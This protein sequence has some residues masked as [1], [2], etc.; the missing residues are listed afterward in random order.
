MANAQEHNTISIRS[1]LW[2]YGLVASI[3]SLAAAT[4]DRVAHPVVSGPTARE[5]ILADVVWYG[6]LLVCLVVPLMISVFST[7]PSPGSRSGRVEYVVLIGG[8]LAGFCIWPIDRLRYFGDGIPL[9]LPYIG[10]GTAYSILAQDVVENIR[11]REWLLA[12]AHALVS[13]FAA[14]VVFS[15][16][17]IV[18]FFE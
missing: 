2:I 18:V 14:S 10:A 7:R 16:S 9:V 8:V 3:G 12:V 15:I 4:W 6:T 17:W 11:H 1:M 13:F 5:A